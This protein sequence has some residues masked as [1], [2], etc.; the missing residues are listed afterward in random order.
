MVAVE[1]ERD[2]L[3]EGIMAEVIRQHGSPGQRLEESPVQSDG[4]SQSED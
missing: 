3:S 4:P 2:G 1:G